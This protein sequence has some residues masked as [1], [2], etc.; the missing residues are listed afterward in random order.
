MKK[1]KEK[2]P[3][4]IDI[5]PQ[6]IIEDIRSRCADYFKTTILNP[7]KNLLTSN[8]LALLHLL[9]F[10]TLICLSYQRKNDTKGTYHTT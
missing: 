3:E 9:I 2:V 4:I 10:T 8:K 1:F 5:I 7:L 6:I